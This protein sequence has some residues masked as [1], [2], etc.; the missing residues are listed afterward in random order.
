MAPIKEGTYPFRIEK[1]ECQEVPATFNRQLEESGDLETGRTIHRLPRA[2]TQSILAAALKPDAS[3]LALI[4]KV[5]ERIRQRLVADPRRY[6]GIGALLTRT[7]LTNGANGYLPIAGLSVAS[8]CPLRRK[9]FMANAFRSSR[10][11]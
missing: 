2:V 11:V 4:E 9:Y 6:M 10:M 8:S 7:R 1:A 5:Y 3:K